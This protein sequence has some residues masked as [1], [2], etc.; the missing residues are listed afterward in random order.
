[1]RFEHGTQC[2]EAG[3]MERKGG[4]RRWSCAISKA[5]KEGNRFSVGISSLWITRNN[6]HLTLKHDEIFV[7]VFLPY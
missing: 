7:G 3:L 4:T 6:M 1:M 2:F 5:A